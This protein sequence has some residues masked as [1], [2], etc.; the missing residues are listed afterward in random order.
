MKPHHSKPDCRS[1]VF[2]E[3]VFYQGISIGVSCNHPVAGRIK[4]QL[5]P[6][7]GDNYEDCFF[8]SSTCCVTGCLFWETSQLPA[9]RASFGFSIGQSVVVKTAK[10]YLYGTIINR[11]WRHGDKAYTLSFTNFNFGYGDRE[12]QSSWDYWEYELAPMSTKTGW[13]LKNKIHSFFCKRNMA[14]VE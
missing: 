10:R 2:A 14:I 5:F 12:I 13:W 8:R 1:C 3:E 6:Y 7:R 4:N 11:R 9:K